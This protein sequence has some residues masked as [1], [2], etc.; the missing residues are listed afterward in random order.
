MK[1]KVLAG[2]LSFALAFSMLP[3][4]PYADGGSQV[5]YAEEAVTRPENRVWDLASDTVAVRPSVEKT[6]GEFDGIQIDASAGKFSP[7]AGDT[8]VN[9]GTVMTIPVEANSNGAVLT[10]RLSGGSVTLAVGET[11]YV[12]ASGA[13]AIE[14]DSSETAT[15]CTVS[16]V[17]QTY[18]ASIELTYSE[19]EEEYPGVPED[20]E[21]A[22]TT[23]S[24]ESAD[25]FLGAD[26]TAP[27]NSTLEGVRGTF[28]D[29]K[30]DASASGAKFALQTANA[31]V[32]VNAGTVLYIPAAYDEAGAELLISGTKDG[33]NASAIK[34]N[35]V[36]AM[37]NDRLALD[38]SDASAY[39]QYIKVEFIEQC[40]V[41]GI[42]LNY[43][44]DSDYPDPEVT[45]KDKVWNFAADGD[46]TRPDLQGN[47]GEY[48][49]IQ[50]DARTGK[51]SPRDGDVQVN[52]GTTLYIPVAPD[53]EGASITVAA[54]NYN[55]LT[56]TMD[57]ETLVV[58]EETALPSVDA[59]TYVPLI[60]GAEGE[61]GSCYLYNITVDYFSDNEVNVNTVTVGVGEGYDY[62]RI[63]DALDAN[64]S[65]SSAP[66]VLKIAPGTYSEKVTVD[67]PW[68]SFQPLEADGGDIIIEAS[69]YSSNT[70]NSEGN[71]VPQDEYDLG[72]DQS[73]TV[74][75]TANAT[76]F[77]AEGITFQNSYNIE[78]HTAE[79]EQTPAVALGS[80]ADRVYFK[81]CKFIGRQDT[82]YLHGT[83]ARVKV[84]DSYIEGTVDFIFGDADAYFANCELHMAAYEG[85]DTGYF[86][87]ANTKKGDTGLVFDQCTLTVDESYGEGSR[88][89]LGRPWQTEC[90]TESTRT[91]DGTV[92]TVYDPDRKNPVYENTASS[93]TFI[94]CTMDSAI[95]DTRWNAWT[96]KHENGETVDVTY[97]PDVHF[98]EYNSKDESG[99]YL[100]PADYSDIVLGTMELVD[101]TQEVTDGLLS[102]MG[103]GSGIGNWTPSLP[104]EPVAENPFIDV[105]DDMY[106][107]DSI[108]W[109]Y[110]NG[111]ATGLDDIHFEP[112]TA[113]TRGQIV[114]FLWRS[115]GQPEPTVAENPFV[116]L[117]EDTYYYKAILWA[118]ENGIVSGIDSEHFAPNDM[119][120][121]AL[122]VTML[123]CANGSPKCSIENPFEDVPEAFYTDAV[124]WAYE[125]KITTGIDATHFSPDEYCTRG[126][127]VEFLYRAQ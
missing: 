73:G 53:A 127:A 78:D 23:Y 80:V 49:G 8:Q 20:V 104:E 45:A 121:R 50:I 68:V 100:D 65:S 4:I 111:I 105:G 117:G 18:L 34:V 72:T 12:S 33:S 77:S 52:A 79:G 62:E 35:G 112:E 24:F 115:M 66:L 97:H 123:Y 16:F 21:A 95:Q 63:Q 25:G 14:L 2:L 64:E 90:Y 7:R 37:S 54:N 26:G 76:G 6:S 10:F 70:F 40:Y 43:V 48:D 98:A 86:T 122:F 99:A 1:K 84:E 83:G 36:D 61:T 125:N 113:C 28:H 56:V 11:Q 19:P 31:R 3:G 9:A 106:Y 75:L 17:T 85:R 41:T 93:V 114:M 126:Q 29:M 91:E 32:Q 15:D 116:D 92:V 69:Y 94:E 82:L 107:Y 71:F 102:D 67:K 58:G 88:V 87:A 46:V 51:F 47:Q 96:R 119:V 89:S 59:N 81:D 57:G 101:N 5:V 55:N 108:L 110:E 27:A 74:L 118:Y 13:V 44:S 109:A 103:F 22:D 30:I 124:L 60:F 120:T 39:P 38:M 42:S